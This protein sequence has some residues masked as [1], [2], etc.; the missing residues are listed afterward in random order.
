MLDT[1]CKHLL[2]HPDLYHDEMARFLLD[3]FDIQVSPQSIGRAL[4]SIKWTKKKIRRI[5]KRQNA[6]LRD[7]YIYNT[8]D[9][10]PKQFVFIN[11]SDTELQTD[12]VVS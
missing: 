6:D 7:L 5:A 12:G 8:K 11:E 10:S 1:L 4:R 2:R 9:F 3:E